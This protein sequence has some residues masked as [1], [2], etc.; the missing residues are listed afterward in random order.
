MFIEAATE[1]GVEDQRDY[2][3]RNSDYAL[4]LKQLMR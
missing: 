2:R 1:H 3:L 4:M